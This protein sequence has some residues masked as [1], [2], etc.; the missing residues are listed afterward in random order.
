MERNSFYI[1][2]KNRSQILAFFQPY[3]TKFHS[4]RLLNYIRVNV[5]TISTPNSKH[6]NLFK[7][8]PSQPRQKSQLTLTNTQ[9]LTPQRKAQLQPKNS[10]NPKACKPNTHKNKLT[11][12][13]M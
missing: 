7:L 6:L 3:G 9:S 8:N 13:Y 11:Y 10:K 4:S 12:K 5:H 2:I 1:K